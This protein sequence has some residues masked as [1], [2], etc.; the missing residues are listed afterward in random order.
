MS[1]TR[2]SLPAGTE[3]FEA[4]GVRLACT[5]TGGDGPAIVLVHG[6]WGSHRN[7][8]PVVPGLAEHFRVITYDRRGHSDSG[9]P[10]GQGHFSEDAADLAADTEQTLPA[11]R[12]PAAPG[13]R[14]R[15]GNGPE[16]NA[17]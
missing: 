14:R 5:D 7:W 16:R 6:S 12:T 8:D 3:L 4:N 15:L 9:H 13:G 1:T 2:S 11:K 17:P 10:P